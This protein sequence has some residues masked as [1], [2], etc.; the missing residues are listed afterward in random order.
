MYY[1]IDSGSESFRF[2]RSS[3]RRILSVATVRYSPEIRANDCV[4]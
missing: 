4:N 1:T 3:Y 2:D